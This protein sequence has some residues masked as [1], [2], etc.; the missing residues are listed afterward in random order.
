MKSLCGGKKSNAL[1]GYMESAS[2]RSLDFVKDGGRR[3][4]FDGVIKALSAWE[5]STSGDSVFS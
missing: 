5:N 3:N 2:E 4:Y 1:S